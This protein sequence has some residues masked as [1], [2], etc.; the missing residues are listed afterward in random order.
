MPIIKSFAVERFASLRDLQCPSGLGRVTVF[1]AVDDVSRYR[2]DAPA[3]ALRALAV[4]LRPHAPSVWSTIAVRHS[5]NECQLAGRWFAAEEIRITSMFAT[6]GR[7]SVIA[8]WRGV[9]SDGAPIFVV[10]CVDNRGQSSLQIIVVQPL[11]AK[12]EDADEFPIAV[13]WQP[14]GMPSVYVLKN[15]L[16]AMPRSD[17][18]RVVAIMRHLDPAIVELRVSE[19]ADRQGLP[20]VRVLT[21]NAAHDLHQM[22]PIF[23]L[24]LWRAN[25]LLVRAGEVLLWPYYDREFGSVPDE[26]HEDFAAIAQERKCNLVVS[27]DHGESLCRAFARKCPD[28]VR[29]SIGTKREEERLADETM[30]VE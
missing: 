11:P 30:G 27:C 12:R 13:R 8:H 18:S 21:R 15:T 20:A 7:R 6:F 22:H 28:T 17:R 25:S 4:L 23:S 16:H 26:V 14:P 3:N 19:P 2:D 10:N 1:D 5:V 24:I 29:Y 9:D